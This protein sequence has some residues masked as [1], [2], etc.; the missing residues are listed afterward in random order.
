M[1]LR[2]LRYFLSVCDEGTVS[3]GARRMGIAQPALS[4]QIRKLEES[5]G[6]RLFDRGP[7]QAILTAAGRRLMPEARAIVLRADEA[8]ET[9]R[10]AGAGRFGSL[11]VG[12]AD[13][14]RS[15]RVS[16]K[17]RSF[18]SKHRSIRTTISLL[19]DCDA[20]QGARLGGFDVIIR[21]GFT[22]DEWGEERLVE[23]REMGLVVG[24]R[25]RLA[26]RSSA[27]STDVAG[28]AILL[29]SGDGRD[30]VERV[31]RA[32]LPGNEFQFSH[33]EEGRPL[34]ARI[35]QVSLGIG[36]TVGTHEAAEVGGRRV[37]WVALVPGLPPL[38]TRL[39]INP[40]SDA[41]ILPAFCDAVAS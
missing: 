1:E 31:I 25:H 22:G 40:D 10:D 35:W 7:R 33:S 13:S 30:P 8:A 32:A 41:V 18:F 15:K 34:D 37:S 5:L 4:V 12:V 16:K 21:V 11:R 27:C 9:L 39:K 3:A 29:S 23:T 6:V 26:G 17:L 38:E 24:N 19:P 36:L 2:Q 20:S 28:E 14:A